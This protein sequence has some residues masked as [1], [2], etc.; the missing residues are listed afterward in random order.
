MHA[1]GQQH[2]HTGKGLVEKDKLQAQQPAFVEAWWQRSKALLFFST[3]WKRKE[4]K[5]K[6]TTTV[7]AQWCTEWHSWQRQ[8]QRQWWQMV[9]RRPPSSLHSRN[10]RP[11][12]LFARQQTHRSWLLCTPPAC[13]RH[14]RHC[15]QEGPAAEAS[16]AP[17]RPLYT[18]TAH[19]LSCGMGH[20]A[21]RPRQWLA[22]GSHDAAAAAAVA[23]SGVAVK[24]PPPPPKKCV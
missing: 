7:H 4:R 14:H 16:L 17:G 6:E 19:L 11:A 20:G 12:D 23:G 10:C 21:R 13:H 9:H 2:Q 22:L 18:P 3:V 24:Q 8:R 5:R 1:W 15:C